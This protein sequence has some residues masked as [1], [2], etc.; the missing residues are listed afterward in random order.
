MLEYTKALALRS[1][2]EAERGELIEFARQASLSELRQRLRAQKTPE[3]KRAK[4]TD[5]FQDVLKM[6]TASDWTRLSP[7]DRDRAERPPAGSGSAAQEVKV[8]ASELEFR[9]TRNL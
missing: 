8:G 9:S 7:A 2:P 1:T 4:N 5:A 6:L 3:L